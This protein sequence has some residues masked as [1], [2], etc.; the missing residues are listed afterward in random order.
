MSNENRIAPAAVRVFEAR[1]HQLGVGTS[2]VAL[3]RAS[4]QQL[5]K[6]CSNS[7]R[8]SRVSDV[9]GVLLGPVSGF[10]L[11]RFRN[12]YRARIHPELFVT[13]AFTLTALLESQR[14]LRGHSSR[15]HS[16]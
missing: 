13:V 1:C 15:N 10:N 6:L 14:R 11:F 5:H 12:C 3:N 2:A 4:R 9:L 7:Q 8:R 16:Q